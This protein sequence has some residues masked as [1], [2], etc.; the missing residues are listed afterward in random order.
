MHSGPA[1]EQLACACKYTNGKDAARLPISWQRAIDTIPPIAAAAAPR[2]RQSSTVEP[3]GLVIGIAG[4]AGLFSSC[5]EAIDTVTEYRSFASDSGLERWGHD[6]GF[7]NGRLSADHDQRL[8]D[9]QTRSVV[10]NLLTIINGTLGSD[11]RP[12]QAGR[13][14]THLDA[15]LGN[16]SQF[17]TLEGV[18]SMRRKLTWA[19]GGKGDR[20]RLGLRRELGHPAS[21]GRVGGMAA[22]VIGREEEVGDGLV[23]GDRQM[24]DD[25]CAQNGHTGCCLVVDGLDECTAQADG[26][27]SVARFLAD[28]KNII[29]SATRLVVSREE[30]NIRAEYQIPPEDVSADAAAYARD[31]ADRKLLSKD[32]D[33][34]LKTWKKLGQLQRA[35]DGTGL[36]RMYERNWEEITR[37]D[38]RDRAVALLRWS[39]FAL[40]PLTISEMTEA[41]LIDEDHE[42]LPVDELLDAAKSRGL[43]PTPRSPSLA[44]GLGG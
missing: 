5:L 9:T 8:D 35:L 42:D 26:T 7:E 28:I 31:I 32:E 2:S 17:R 38:Q 40:R 29:T 16:T 19:L 43:W 24:L 39:A 15:T 23:S 44:S 20:V 13:G 10:E 21:H 33:P 37:S 18:G 22:L 27:S 14:H 36:D 4:L 6:V 1:E 3:A 30:T 12:H 11:G 34:T 25:A 41:V